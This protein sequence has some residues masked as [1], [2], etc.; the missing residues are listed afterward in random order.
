MLHWLHLKG[1]NG[2]DTN[3]ICYTY[4]EFA[5]KQENW[6]ASNLYLPKIYINSSNYHITPDSVYLGRIVASDVNNFFNTTQRF[7]QNIEV[8]TN[9]ATPLIYLCN[10]DSGIVTHTP[11]INFNSIETGRI[12]LHADAVDF[13]LYRGSNWYVLYQFY[14]DHFQFG[15]S[16]SS[17]AVTGT[18]YGT[19][20][21]SAAGT[22][23]GVV[24]AVYF[25]ATSDKRAKENLQQLPH[26]MLDLVNKMQVYTYQ[27]KDSKQK[28]LGLIAQDLLDINLNGFSLVENPNATGENGDYMSIHESKLVYI[29]LGAVQ[30]LSQEVQQL[31]KE[32][33]K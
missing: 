5:E 9:I 3:S 31:K 23:T 30:E 29:L 4:V 32:L 7:N 26:S 22:N 13:S 8:V 14:N 12:S 33:G 19:L 2:S 15:G 18:I 1:F 16:S 6:T 27:Y 21:V 17:Y 11:W 24:N 10:P 20:T 25:N 28:S